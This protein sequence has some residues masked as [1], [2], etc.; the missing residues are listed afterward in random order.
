MELELEVLSVV[1]GGGGKTKRA[2]GCSRD[3]ESVEYDLDWGGGG[4]GEQ[5]G[6]P[7]GGVRCD[8]GFEGG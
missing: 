1:L 8:R 2:G 6:E 5:F 7:G 3:G 4:E